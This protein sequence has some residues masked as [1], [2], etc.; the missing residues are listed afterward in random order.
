MKAMILAA[1]RGERLKPLT[2]KIPK[3]LL[4]VG[5]ERLIERHIRQLARYGIHE[6][7]INTH[8][9][10]DLIQQTLGDGSRFEVSIQYSD[11]SAALLDTGGGISHALSLLGREP[12]LV[13]NSDIICDYPL[14]PRQLEEHTSM[15]LVMVNNPEHNAKGDFHFN[16]D[17]LTLSAGNKL[18]FSGIGYYRPSLFENR[19]DIFRVADLIRE[20]ITLDKVSAEHF[21][22]RWMDIGSPTRL[23]QATALM[24]LK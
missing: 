24:A 16:R 23:H 12:F 3:P 6:I 5:G 4:R 11:E 21:Q 22:G 19:P 18:T 10:A 14:Q 1:G 20:Q 7:V 13:V 2:D 17:R 15:H 9:L 8:H